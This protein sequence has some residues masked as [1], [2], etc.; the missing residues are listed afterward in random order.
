MNFGVYCVRDVKAGFQSPTIQVNDAVAVR[1]FASAVMQS[2]SVLFTHA[3]D[4]ALYKLA[5]FDADTGR[6]APL[7]LPV[8]LMQASSCLK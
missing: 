2:D 1:G 5:E 8:E 3:S 4:F 7:D 6:I